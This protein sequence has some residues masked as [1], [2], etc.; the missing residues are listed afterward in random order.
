MVALHPK[1]EPR[2]EA[3]AF[4]LNIRT[5]KSLI[6]KMSIDPVCPGIHRSLDQPP[7]NLQTTTDQT[8]AKLLDEIAIHFN[9]AVTII[10]EHPLIW[11]ATCTSC[12][13]MTSVRQ[14]SWV[15][16]MQPR[17]R[18]CGGQF[19]VATNDATDSPIVYVH[20]TTDSEPELLGLSCR[21][22]GLPPLSFVEATARGSESIIFE[23]AGSIDHL[24]NLGDA[25]E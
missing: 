5:G 7:V 8:V 23:M 1:M 24:F 17:C 22:I 4:D 13:R 25:H 15:W 10:L 16:Q 2:F 12:E 21:Q 9:E 6:V 14:P 18:D 11:S 20:I 3:R 19:P